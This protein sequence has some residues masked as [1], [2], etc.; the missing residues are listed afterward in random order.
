MTVSKKTPLCPLYIIAFVILVFFSSEEMVWAGD[1]SSVP[2][3][4]VGD[5]HADLVS[6]QK[7]FR[8]AG[9][10]N[11]GGEWILKNTIV[12]Q[13]GDLTDRGPDGKPLLDWIKGLEQQA[14]EHNSQFVVLLGNHEVM[15]LQGD[16]RYVSSMDLDS[17]GGLEARKRAFSISENGNYAEWLKDKDAVVKIG[18]TVF[19]HGGVSKRF[20]RPAETLSEE[21]RQAILGQ[22]DMGVLGEYGPLW[23]RGYWQQ[24][25]EDACTEATEVLAIMGAKRMVMGHT[26]QRD[27]QIHSRCNGTLFAI[28]TGISRHY[29]EHPSA[30]RI[31]GNRVEGMYT[32]G[33]VLL[34]EAP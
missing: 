34:Y 12:V 11:S 2:I 19:V 1:E 15:N 26:T 22:G 13:T 30:L 8:I 7:A 28:D 23:Y 20:A 14:T 31:N 21:V 4:A 24:T 10:T 6:A 27:G 16:W 18:D 29:G 33:T 32:S 3:V 25:E 5:L 9:I 17:F